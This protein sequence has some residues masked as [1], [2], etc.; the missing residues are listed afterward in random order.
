MPT[1]NINKKESPAVK[2]RLLNHWDNL[3]ESVERG[4]AGL[5]IWKWDEING[6]K[7]TMS[8]TLKERLTTYCRAN[9]S[10]G[11]NGSVINNVNASPKMLNTLYIKR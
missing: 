3:D 5:S 7:G 10:I 4:Y 2:Y 11:I 9:A 8:L 1:G 6:D